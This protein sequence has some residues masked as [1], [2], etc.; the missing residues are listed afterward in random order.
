MDGEGDRPRRI[1]RQSAGCEQVRPPRQVGSFTARLRFSERRAQ[2]PALARDAREVLQQVRA[3]AVRACRSVDA[4][5]KPIER[6]PHP[7][8]PFVAGRGSGRKDQVRH[9][10]VDHPAYHAL[11]SR[12][13]RAVAR[14]ALGRLGN[15][16]ARDP[17]G[18]REARAVDEQVR[19]RVFLRAEHACANGGV[20]SPHPFGPPCRARCVRR[21]VRGRVRGDG[22]KQGGQL[23]AEHV[24]DRRSVRGKDDGARQNE[25]QRVQ[26]TRGPSTHCGAADRIGAAL[27]AG[28]RRQAPQ[29]VGSVTAGG[30]SVAGR[31]ATAVGEAHKRSSVSQA[32]SPAKSGNPR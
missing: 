14:R 1:G 11:D 30:P 28:Y 20:A 21:Q 22:G 26:P 12:R 9:A 19:E 7:R 4:Q 29:H 23:T 16:R 8:Q 5:A 27:G 13:P 6:P 24:A 2:L 10:G 32:R 15:E 18:L 25:G 3:R 31:A 17:R